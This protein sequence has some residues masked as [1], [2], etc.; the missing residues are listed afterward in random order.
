[1]TTSHSNHFSILMPVG[2]SS[3][4]SCFV[5]HF[6]SLFV[7]PT[8]SAFTFFSEGGSYA[9]VLSLAKQATIL[10]FSASN[11]LFPSI[12]K[13]MSLMMNVQTSSQKR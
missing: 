7:N 10:I 9:A 12:L 11:W 6:G 1:M 4:G 5:S 3:F 2:V 13:W 8:G